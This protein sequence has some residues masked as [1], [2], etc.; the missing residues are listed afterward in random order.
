MLI[1]KPKTLDQKEKERILSK[2][3]RDLKRIQEEEIKKQ[4]NKLENDNSTLKNESNKKIEELI[5]L[6]N[7]I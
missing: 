5:T 1:F 2:A 6:I 3:L 4:L 7:Y